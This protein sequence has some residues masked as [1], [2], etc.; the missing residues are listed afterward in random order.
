M[1]KLSTFL[2]LAIAA[3]ILSGCYVSPY[4]YQQTGYRC[5]PPEL[6]PIKVELAPVK[7][8]PLEVKPLIVDPIKLKVEK[9]KPECP[10][11]YPCRPACPY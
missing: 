5:P 8:E 11:P 10:D 2:S 9:K 6:P 1:K 4:N 3:T 7:V